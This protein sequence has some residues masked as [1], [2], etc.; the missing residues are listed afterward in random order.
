MNRSITMLLLVLISRTGLAQIHGIQYEKLLVPIAIFQPIAGAR[1]SL[2]TSS[3]VVRSDAAGEVAFYPIYVDCMGIGLCPPAQKLPAAR[4]MSLIVTGFPDRP[5]ELLFVDRDH[6]SELAFT[7]RVQDLSRQS[8]TWGTEIPVIHE[9]EFRTTKLSLADVPITSAF[10]HTLR[11][12]DPDNL[13]N[14]RVTV[15]VIGITAAVYPGHA[16]K[17][18]GEKSLPL[19]LAPAG[20]EWHSPAYLEIADLSQIAPLDGYE[21]VLVE[22]EPTTPGLRLWAFVSV[23]NNETQ[24]VTVVTP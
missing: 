19:R 1:G 4:T 18:L 14:G 2:W 12:Y 8:Q 3:L 5:T 13:P 9:R 22:V 20:H 10:R 23:T 24:H 21:R 6:A 7:L 16:D 11:I 17:L 15:R